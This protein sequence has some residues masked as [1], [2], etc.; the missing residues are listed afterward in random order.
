MC[1]DACGRRSIVVSTSSIAGVGIVSTL[2]AAAMLVI[3]VLKRKSRQKAPM[4][5]MTVFF[6]FMRHFFQHNVLCLT[7]FSN[8]GAITRVEIYRHLI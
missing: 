6:V 4:L 7:G 2:Y 1:L 5:F 3:I 8:Y